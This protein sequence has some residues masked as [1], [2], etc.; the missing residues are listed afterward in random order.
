[1]L[2]NHSPCLGFE[3]LSVGVSWETP[4]FVWMYL[5]HLRFESAS[6]TLLHAESYIHLGFTS[7]RERATQSAQDH[8]IQSHI[9][10]RIGF[11]WQI[12]YDT[13]P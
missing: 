1:M 9:R 11:Y 7:H 4:P 2:D 3:N 13:G 10:P 6:R 5:R 8:A 12:R